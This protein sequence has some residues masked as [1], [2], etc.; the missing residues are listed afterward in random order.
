MPKS[1]PSRTS[2]QTVPLPRDEV[3]NKGQ[4]RGVSLGLQAAK[5][6]TWELD[7]KTQKWLQHNSGF[8]RG[9][10]NHCFIVSA[11]PLTLHEA[12]S[13]GQMV[14]ACW[15]DMNL[16][17]TKATELVGRAWSLGSSSWKLHYNQIIKSKCPGI[18]VVLWKD[19]NHHCV[20]TGT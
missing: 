1:L 17:C 3:F 14:Y 8:Y 19:L 5:N 18:W 12:T 16:S 10:F 6:K 20:C 7:H 15:T 2:C 13:L 11:Q 9:L 4:S